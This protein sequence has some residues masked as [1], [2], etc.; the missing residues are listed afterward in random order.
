MPKE[1]DVVTLKQMTP[2][3]PLPPG[4]RGTILIVHSADPPAYEVEFVDDAGASL[5]TY[6]AQ[7]AELNIDP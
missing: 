3:I 2:A 5:G 4:S 1:F 6:T 7:A